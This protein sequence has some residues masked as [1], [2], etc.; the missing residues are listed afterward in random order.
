MEKEQ[1]CI[2]I[3]NKLNEIINQLSKEKGVSKN[4]IIVNQ[5][6]NLTKECEHK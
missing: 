1:V 3:P 5:L 6:W 2:R 4:S